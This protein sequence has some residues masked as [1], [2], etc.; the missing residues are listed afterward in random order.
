MPYRN[1]PLTPEPTLRIDWG[2]LMSRPIVWFA[3]LIRICY[4]F[5]LVTAAII[6]CTSNLNH[7]IYWT[8]LIVVTIFWD[9]NIYNCQPYAWHTGTLYARLAYMDKSDSQ[10]R[11]A[12]DLEKRGGHTANLV[13]DVNSR[14]ADIKTS[15]APRILFGRSR[16]VL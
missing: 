14:V 16:N 1:V 10:S 12:A 2:A 3:Y 7:P 9:D 11:K 6:I 5:W 13:E 15:K 8:A 4:D